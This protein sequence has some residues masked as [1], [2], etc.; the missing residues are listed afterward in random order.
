MTPKA[1]QVRK[2]SILLAL[3]G[4]FI[5][6]PLSA[7]AAPEI[8]LAT[9]KAGPSGLFP[10][11]MI[12]VDELYALQQSDKKLLILDA[13]G[14]SSYDGGHILGAE[15]PLTREHYQQ[16][17]LFR[18]GIVKK[19]PEHTKALQKGMKKYPKTTEIVTYCNNECHASAVLLLELKRMGF[20][21]VRAMEEGFQTWQQKGYPTAA[22][23]AKT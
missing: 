8:D 3:L 12:S 22:T 14:K 21:N 13:R 7:P 19:A 6:Q 4:F 23:P 18:Q 2:F 1:P 10:E 16:E 17:E 20:K 15:L 11:E 5:F 9:A